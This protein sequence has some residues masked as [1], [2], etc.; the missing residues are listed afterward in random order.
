MLAASIDMPT[1]IITGFETLD[2]RER[3]LKCGAAARLR[4]PADGQAL[5]DAID[6]VVDSP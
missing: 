2:S 4:K 6:L 3:A 5:L 1:V